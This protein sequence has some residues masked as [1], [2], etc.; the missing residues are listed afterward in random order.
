MHSPNTVRTPNT[1]SPIPTLHASQ[2][3]T[4]QSPCAALTTPLYTHCARTPQNTPIYRMHKALPPLLHTHCM[5]PPA[6]LA[7]TFIPI[8]PSGKPTSVLSHPLHPSGNPPSLDR[9]GDTP[10]QPP[11]R[12]TQPCRAKSKTHPSCSTSAPER[13]RWG[14]PGVSAPALP[15][16]PTPLWWG[17]R[18]GRFSTE[19]QKHRPGK[20]DL[21]G[22]AEWCSPLPPRLL[23]APDSDA[24]YLPPAH[25]CSQS[26]ATHRWCKCNGLPEAD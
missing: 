21:S 26:S 17:R 2:H 14:Q 24:N 19:G 16:S 22:G 6:P 9:R 23:T 15:L 3:P 4:P 5:N 18:M 11:K 20:C 7:F 13:A 10:R 12:W 8:H 25:P 1:L